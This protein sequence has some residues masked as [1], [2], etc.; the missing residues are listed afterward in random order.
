M[1]YLQMKKK[2]MLNYVSGGRLPSEY[3]EVEWVGSSGRQGIDLIT[4][5]SNAD[6]EYI[7]EIEPTYV[8]SYNAIITEQPYHA[9]QNGCHQKVYKQ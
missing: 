2:A 4:E 5:Q 1:N 6:Y 7:A 9:G 3:Q 8:G